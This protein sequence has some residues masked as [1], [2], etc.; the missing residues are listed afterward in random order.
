MATALSRKANHLR[1]S[2]RFLTSRY[3]S[4][5]SSKPYIP[6]SPLLENPNLPLP[7][8]V[9]PLGGGIQ[10]LP[11]SQR[12]LFSTTAAASTVDSESSKKTE[13]DKS[14][15]NEK[16]G[17]SK[18]QDNNNAGRPLRR[19]PISW[20]SFLLLA[21]TG[22][23]LIWYYDRM[24]K[25]RIEALNKTSSIVKEGPSVGKAEI[26]GPFNLIDHDGKPVTE[27]DFMGKWTMIYFGFTHC[28]DICPDELQ[29]LAA[30]IDKIKE[31]AGFDIVPVF[32][33]VDP[34]RDNVEQVREYVKEFHPKLIGLTGSLEE[35]QKTARAY[36]IYYMKTSEEDSDYLVDHSII[37]YLMDPNMELVKFFGKNNDA[38]ALVDGV[39]KEIKHYMVSGLAL[40]VR[41]IWALKLKGVEYEYIEENLLNK[42]E[43]LLKYNPIYKK[44][45]VLVHGGSP[46]AESLIILEY[47]EE[48]WPENPLL[49]K[50]PY[51][52]A[53]A[54]F[55]I[56]YEGTKCTEALGAFFRANKE[57][58]EKAGK[59]LLE[60]LKILEEQGLGDKKFFGGE[61]IN[62]ADIS[63]GA[64]AY[65]LPAMEEAI[66]VKVL[67]RST[68]PKLHAWAKNFMV[69]PVIKENIPDYDKMLA[70]IKVC[71]EKFA[72]N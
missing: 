42:S 19:G 43:L 35:I 56:Q 38:D 53:M 28:P 9:L 64:C 41:V 30:A 5:C 63:Y 3:L 29:K 72:K 47:I 69:V 48:T 18:R 1:N 52:R 50:D 34:E 61:N 49:P 23:G 20:L 32:I 14:D 57:E 46:I 27:K 7:R 59:E 21:A 60:V 33:T 70:H 26:G 10:S 39:I 22:A 67:E 15:G 65:W 45:P 44:I 2:Y 24:K 25:R 13:E 6:F 68:L 54:R 51:D 4:Q 36:R 11:I 40:V 31:K 66:G 62:L 55:W 37:T 17:D 58:R 12:F 8:S 71:R 16:S